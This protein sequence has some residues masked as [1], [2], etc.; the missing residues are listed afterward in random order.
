MI[1]KDKLII[2][3][4]LFALCTMPG[5]AQETTD[6]IASPGKPEK[7]ADQVVEIG[8]R[9]AQRLEESTS[10][11]STV[12]NE[13][14]NKRSAKNIGNSLFGYGTGLMTLQGTGTY[15][16][17]EP[18]F[19]VRGLQTLSSTSPLVL[20]DGIERDITDITP[21]EVESVTVLKDASAVAIYGYKGINGV[22]NITTKRGQYNTREVKFSYD[23]GFEWQARRPKFADSY[24]YANAINEALAMMVC[25]PVI[26]QMN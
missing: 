19:F 17:Y 25:Q 4:A 2:P 23:H 18:T 21:E 10:S 12:Y 13:E 11:V 9:T 24:T 8:Y 14:F 26:R 6:S 20:V 1:R 3:A 16:N 7:Y 5:Y 22:V 15:A